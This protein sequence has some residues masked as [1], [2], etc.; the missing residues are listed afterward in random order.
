MDKHFS[1]EVLSATTNPQGLV[2]KAL[3]QC[4]SSKPAAKNFLETCNEKAC[5]EIIVRRLLSGNRGHYSPLE[6]ANITFACKYFNHGTVQQ[7]TRHRT[8]ISFAVQ[9]FRYTGDSIIQCAKNSYDAFD[10]IEKAF[11]LRPVGNYYD[12][13][14]KKYEYTYET[15]LEHL[16]RCRNA[17]REYAANVGAGMP[18]EQARGLLPFDY[19]QHMVMGCNA[20]TLMHLLD[21][22]SPRDAQLEVRWISNL[23][24]NAFANWMPEVAAWYQENRLGKSKLAP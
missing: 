10:D 13:N 19:R 12:R 22:R 16:E 2:Y 23:L 15:R 18:E 24:F 5:G 7:L 9:S 21:M 6:M 11:Y 14:G 3:H 17:A 4:Y 8:G 1:L 20:R